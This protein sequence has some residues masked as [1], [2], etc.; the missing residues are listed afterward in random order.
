MTLEEMGNEYNEQWKALME[1]I[2]QLRKNVEG[3]KPELK[4]KQLR[5]IYSLMDSAAVC[6]RSAEKLTN[7]YRRDE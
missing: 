7:Y 2:L 5:R 3:L 4:R 6:K 1:R